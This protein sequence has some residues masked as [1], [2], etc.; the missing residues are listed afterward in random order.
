MLGN[1]SKPLILFAFIYP[2]EVTFTLR[3]PAQGKNASES[4]YFAVFAGLREGCQHGSRQL[5]Y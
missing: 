2:E 3:T 4:M 5:Q 1:L